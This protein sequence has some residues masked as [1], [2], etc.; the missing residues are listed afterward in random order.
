MRNQIL[1]GALGAFAFAL[2][3]AACGKDAAPQ[4]GGDRPVTVTTQVLRPQPWNDTLQALGTVK[5]QIR[6][7]LGAMRRYLEGLDAAP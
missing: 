2:L 6:R 7:S 1:P 4:Q 3:L 5:A